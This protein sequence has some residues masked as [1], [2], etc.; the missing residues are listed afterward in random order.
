[1]MLEFIFSIFILLENGL[2]VFNYFTILN[3]EVGCLTLKKLFEKSPFSPVD[4][5]E[6]IEKA[7]LGLI[8]I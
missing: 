4:N 7:E 6:G 2:K 1:M 3:V 8:F 5:R